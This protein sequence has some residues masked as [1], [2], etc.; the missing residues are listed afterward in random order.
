MS[1]TRCV[2]CASPCSKDWPSALLRYV[3]CNACKAQGFFLFQ[4]NNKWHVASRE[5][6][7]QP[8]ET[9]RHRHQLVAPGAVR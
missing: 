2:R 4:R 9:L 6:G 5:G 8:C 7:S 1:E 3:L